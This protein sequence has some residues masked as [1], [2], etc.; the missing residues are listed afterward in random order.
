MSDEQLNELTDWIKSLS[1]RVLALELLAI[2][3]GV[4]ADLVDAELA[5]MRKNEREEMK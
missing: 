2:R 5:R 4:G 3:A 1:E